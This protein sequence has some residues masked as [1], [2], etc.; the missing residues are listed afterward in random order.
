MDPQYN[1][2]DNYFKSDFNDPIDDD[3]KR[4]RSSK[5]I[6]KNS[7]ESIKKRILEMKLLG[8]EKAKKFL[9][10]TAEKSKPI[11]DKI[12][13]FG[14]TPVK[15]TIGLGPLG[16]VA[17]TG[18]TSYLLGK[19]IDDSFGYLTGKK[20][21]DRISSPVADDGK[22]D[23][24]RAPN[25]SF[26]Q[27]R[28]DMNAR[29]D[30]LDNFSNIINE[31]TGRDVGPITPEGIS[32]LA[33]ELAG[34]ERVHG[35]ESFMETPN[36][37]T[38]FR[39]DGT[40]IPN[41]TAPELKYLQDQNNKRL[42]EET[43]FGQAIFSSTQSQDTP[44][45]LGDGTFGN[46]SARN[47]MRPEVPF[48]D[49]PTAPEDEPYPGYYDS[50]LYA[51]SQSLQSMGPGASADERTAA[52][53]E[54][55]RPFMT[56]SHED[57]VAK[58]DVIFAKA[59]QEAMIK[60]AMNRATSTLRSH[61]RY[62]DQQA[63]LQGMGIPG[64]GTYKA[65]L[66]NAGFKGAG[67]T[68]A[69]KSKRMEDILNRRKDF[70]GLEAQQLD[71]SNARRGNERAEIKLQM[72]TEAHQANMDAAREKAETLTKEEQEQISYNAF[73]SAVNG[74]K[75]NPDQQYQLNRYLKA[76]PDALDAYGLSEAQENELR[77]GSAARIVPTLKEQDVTQREIDLLKSVGYN[78]VE[79][80]G[81]VVAID[82]IPIPEPVAPKPVTQPGRDGR[83][84]PKPDTRSG[85]QRLMN[86]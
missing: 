15:P 26:V 82:S 66:R 54:M 67:M 39:Q 63:M 80:N 77:T 1:Y 31:A 69:A 47:Q 58:N 25:P 41:L 49:L 3:L 83:V 44:F 9:Q 21:S 11:A 35:V 28:S 22:Y 29:A 56:T 37:A 65:E 27:A 79:Y 5:K 68:G 81:E 61:E 43:G 76:N 57:M 55:M 45:D 59:A 23:P 50:P 7:L 78:K 64:L 6:N 20:I 38:G 52:A 46:E 48:S 72:E 2:S 34:A 74:E 60:D 71:I 13:T 84:F 19:G 16:A 24:N 75:L 8:E 36:A 17:S 30:M 51:M 42:M 10:E 40:A 70:M 86:Q 62:N 85:F 33:A 73:R 12:K 14:K 18:M 4:E 32:K 53:A